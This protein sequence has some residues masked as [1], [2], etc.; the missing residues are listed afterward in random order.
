MT[1]TETRS[2]SGS[3]CPQSPK[4]RRLRGVRAARRNPERSRGSHPYRLPG[5]P[6][7]RVLWRVAN[8]SASKTSYS[9]K[10]DRKITGGAPRL[11]LFETW[12]FQLPIPNRCAT[13]A[14][15]EGSANRRHQEPLRRRLN[16]IEKRKR[17]SRAHGASSW[18]RTS[19][20]PREVRHPILRPGSRLEESALVYSDSADVRHPPPQPSCRACDILDNW[21]QTIP[22]YRDTLVQLFSLSSSGLIGVRSE[23]ERTRISG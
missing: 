22:E 19:R 12:A 9:L 14:L 16:W 18:L 15:R 3:R 1:R 21:S 20:K 7:L 17:R 8:I 2:S 4:L 11:A 10:V 6:S 23:Y 5:A 13:R